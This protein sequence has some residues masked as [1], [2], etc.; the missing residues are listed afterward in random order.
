VKAGEDALALDRETESIRRSRLLERAS[1]YRQMAA[2]TRDATL[3]KAA[4]IG[5]TGAA[6]ILARG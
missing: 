4:G 5:L 6:S 1:S 2:M 3:A